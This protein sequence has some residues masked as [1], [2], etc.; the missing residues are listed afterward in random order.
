MVL[1]I[2]AN[3]SC[4]WGDTNAYFLYHLGAALYE[5]NANP[6]YYRDSEFWDRLQ[7]SFQASPLTNVVVELR[8]VAD[9]ERKEDEDT[10]RWFKLL[11]DDAIATYTEYVRREQ[12]EQ[13]AQAAKREAEQRDR[14]SSAQDGAAARAVKMQQQR[15][16]GEQLGTSAEDTSAAWKKYMAT[17]DNSHWD[18]AEEDW[19]RFCSTFLAGVVALNSEAILS[20]AK[21]LIE[22]LNLMS[23]QEKI[24]TLNRYGAKLVVSTGHSVPALGHKHDERSRAVEALIGELESEDADFAKITL[25]RRRELVR[26]VLRG[27]Y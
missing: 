16:S 27:A 4:D 7:M 21:A 15:G 3:A 17:I 22:A 20:Y 24:E 13:Q 6:S 11:Y 1:S 26:Y 5:R 10:S 12:V 25:E 14:I 19:P 8:N 2:F 9:A 18:G 23:V